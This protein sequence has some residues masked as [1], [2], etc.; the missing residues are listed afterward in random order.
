MTQRRIRA[1]YMRGGTSRCLVFHETDLPPAGPE[2]D[3]I[4][5][6]A[7]G[8]PDPYGRQLNGLGGGISSLSKACIIGPSRHP[9]ADVDY[10]FA[11]VEVSKPVVDYSGNCGNCSA[12]V[13]PFA[14]DEHL[15][16]STDGETVV[17]IHNT[18]T[19]KLIVAHVPVSGGEAAV[20]GDF[21]LPGVAG[22]G[23]R[24]A[25]DFIDPGGAGTGTL[26]PTGRALD[27]V[28]GVSASLVDAT[29]PVVFVRA[30]DVGLTGT[31]PPPVIDNDRALSARLE[32]I[33]VAAAEMMGIPGNAANP[34][35]VVVAPPMAFVAL[36]GTRHAGD[37]CDL[38][39]RVI[40][41]GN[42]HRAFALTSAMCLAV[43]ARIE[44]TVVREC[45]A[46]RDDADVRLGH[47]SGVLPLD[48]AVAR[49]DGAPWA[50][51]VTVY[52]T[53]RRLMEG[54]VRVP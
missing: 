4:L 47:P 43:A 9:D 16:P 8:S 28:D 44:G 21:E 34:K 2:R 30:K 54:V 32:S 5:L 52:R 42:C 10:T 36:D 18:N 26:L 17:A 31:E 1:V 25:L 37:A 41:M 11:Q 24:I 50:Q 12:S 40:S 7:L 46:A 49:R 6:A 23:A 45:S 39:A 19:A 33:R 35:I 22:R 48:A 51:R 14:I 53:A 27:T 20:E 15:V 13:G 38:V 29:N 3:R